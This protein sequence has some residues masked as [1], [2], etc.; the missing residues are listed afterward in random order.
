MKQLNKSR[1]SFIFFAALL[2]FMGSCGSADKGEKC[3]D[4]FFTNIIKGKYDAAL[5]MVELDLATVDLNVYKNQLQNLG[6]NE[7]DGKLLSAKKTVGFNTSI[8]NGITTVT[9]PYEL[10]YER[11]SSNFEVVIVDRGKGFKISSI[12]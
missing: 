10:K 11:G 6:E 4:K 12:H 9:L 1:V 5:K 8:N 3:A 7:R 2:F